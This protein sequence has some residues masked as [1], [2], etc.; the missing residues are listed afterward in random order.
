M[1]GI[2]VVLVIVALVLCL[3]WLLGGKERLELDAEAR[4][5]M[6][7]ESFVALSDG[8]THYQWGGPERGRKVVFV[9]GFSSPMFIFDPVFRALTDAGLR[10]LRYDLYG[11]GLS[12]RPRARYDADLFDRQ[13]GELLDAQR[14]TE[15]V[16]VVGLS[17]TSALLQ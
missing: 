6:T 7:S 5:D 15:P 9:H 13:L 12:D 14:V 2:I 17:P 4:A 16:D 11:R 10:V 1:L 3:P 8:V